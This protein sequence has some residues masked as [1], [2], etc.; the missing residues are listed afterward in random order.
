MCVAEGRA[1][2][3]WGRRAT[4]VVMRLLAAICIVHTSSASL[5]ERLSRSVEAKDDADRAKCYGGGAMC[6]SPELAD[7]AADPVSP[8]RMANYVID[9]S[10]PAE[11]LDRVRCKRVK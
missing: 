9:P 8:P 2:K 11:R 1:D 3:G 5:R 6:R 7:G 10:F 4:R